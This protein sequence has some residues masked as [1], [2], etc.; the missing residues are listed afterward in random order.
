MQCRTIA[1][2]P[3]MTAIVCGSRTRRAPCSVP[4]CGRP[5]TKLCD[6]PVN[7]KAKPGTCDAKLCD[8]HAT[9]LGP[10]RDICPAHA[11][12]AAKETMP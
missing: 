5:H 2:G 6:A 12:R 3:G 8:A 1:A 11:A 9:K 4:G 10:E 7:R